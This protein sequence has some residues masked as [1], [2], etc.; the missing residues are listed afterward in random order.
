MTGSRW[1]AAAASSVALFY[2]LACADCGTAPYV[3][4]HPSTQQP[5]QS[6]HTPF[7]PE[8]GGGASGPD[9]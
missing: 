2:T 5:H 6:P 1:I 8:D 9:R 3:P 7:A 4:R